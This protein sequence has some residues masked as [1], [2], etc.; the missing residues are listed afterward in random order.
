M[1]TP[2]RHLSDSQG[3]ELREL[4]KLT[5]LHSPN[6]NGDFGHLSGLEFR[7]PLPANAKQRFAEL[8]QELEKKNAQFM[9]LD[10]GKGVFL[11]HTP[12]PGHPCIG[13]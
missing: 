2:E 5:Q 3:K 1:S 12:C 6:G 13:M 7:Q 11:M 4:F 10:A 9:T 8:K